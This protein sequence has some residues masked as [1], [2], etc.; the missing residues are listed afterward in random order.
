MVA[1]GVLTGGGGA[2]PVGMSAHFGF[3]GILGPEALD[4]FGAALVAG[5]EVAALDVDFGSESPRAEDDDFPFALAAS[6]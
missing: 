6:R 2:L 1:G 3:G 5:L 4:D